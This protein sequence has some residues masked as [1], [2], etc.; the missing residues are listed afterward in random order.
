MDRNETKDVDDPFSNLENG[1]IIPFRTGRKVGYETVER[2]CGDVQRAELISTWF[3]G[4]S[5]ERLD[6]VGKVGLITIMIPISDEENRTTATIARRISSTLNCWENREACPYIGVAI[7]DT[8]VRCETSISRQRATAGLLPEHEL[9]NLSS[10]V[11]RDR[12]ASVSR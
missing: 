8:V 7:N 6:H 9:G 1:C 4:R 10:D 5:F 11:E 2:R 3:L 12:T